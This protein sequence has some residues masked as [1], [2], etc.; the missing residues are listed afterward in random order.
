MITFTLHL[1]QDMG[2]NLLSPIVLVPFP[3]PVSVPVP[4]SVDTPQ[5]CC[6]KYANL[7]QLNVL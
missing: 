4:L 2:Q 3:V 5:L 7:T 1:N 6:T